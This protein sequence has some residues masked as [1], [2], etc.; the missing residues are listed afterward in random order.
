MYER[1]IEKDYN[2]GVLVT[3]DIVNG[4]WK[5]CL[6]NLIHSGLQRPSELQRALPDASR[7]SL[8]MQLNELEGHGVITKTIFPVLP[9]KVEYSLT[10]IGESLLPITLAME[11]WGQKYYKNNCK[12]IHKEK[13]NCKKNK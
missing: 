8:N 1:K 6:I 11:E 2:C 9:P 4:K 5:P 3:S 13:L 7:R 12:L 10:E